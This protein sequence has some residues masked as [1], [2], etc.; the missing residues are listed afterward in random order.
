M[1]LV[2]GATGLLGNCC[3]RELV[4]RGEQVRVLVRAGKKRRELDGLN[5]EI[6]E[7]ELDDEAAIDRAVAGTRAVI[8]SAALIHIGWTRLEEARRVNVEGTRKIVEACRRH[9]SRLIHVSTVDTLPAAIDC[10]LPIDETAS[11]L[12]KVECTYV[13]S[14]RESEQVVSDA[15]QSGLD[16]VII[17]PGFMLAPYDWKPSSGQMFLGLARMPAAVAPSGSAS[18]C[19]ARDAAKA[20][21]NSIAHGRRGEHYILGGENIRHGVM[22]SNV[23][24]DGFEDR[25]SIACARV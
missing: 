4:A 25:E 17:H 23:E 5:I 19:D 18:V 16:A 10:S 3:V 15:V 14:K 9:G 24:C 20:I 13:I 8:H 22:D 7:G 6:I 2:T 21:A 1:I 11:G 12:P